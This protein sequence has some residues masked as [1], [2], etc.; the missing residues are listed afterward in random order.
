MFRRF[1]KPELD[2]IIKNAGLTKLQKQIFTLRFYDEDE[3]SVIAICLTLCISEGK[4]YREMKEN[5][6]NASKYQKKVDT[7]VS[8]FYFII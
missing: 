1:T 2:E 5:R 7:L 6:K 8:T 4:Y 3:P